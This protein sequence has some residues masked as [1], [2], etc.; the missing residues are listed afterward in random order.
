M[1]KRER[2]A[3]QT[4]SEQLADLE[5]VRRVDDRPEQADGDRF[6]LLAFQH[7]DHRPQSVLVQRQTHR[8]VRRH[9]LGNFEGQRTRHIGVRIKPREVEGIGLPAF[10]HHQDVGVALGHQQCRP[11][12]T[13][14]DDGVDRVGGP[15]HEQLTSLQQRLEAQAPIRRRQRQGIEDA[16]GGVAWNG[17]R[18]VHPQIIGFDDQV[19]EGAARIAGETKILRVR[20][21]HYGPPPVHEKLP[22]DDARSDA[23]GEPLVHEQGRAVHRLRSLGGQEIGELRNIFRLREDA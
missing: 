1:G 8:A 18:L 7:L 22:L 6:H 16:A 3:G 13:V 20:R 21:Q 15:V 11:R 19:R 23:R 10:A 5:F 12:G 14:S 2:H 9:T 17:V 4:F